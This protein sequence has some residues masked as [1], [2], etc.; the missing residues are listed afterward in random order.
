MNFVYRNA[1]IEF[2]LDKGW[3]CSGYAD[4]STVPEGDGVS[5]WWY[6][7]P[8]S[9]DRAAV[10]DEVRAFPDML[11]LVLDRTKQTREVVARRG[12]STATTLLKTQWRN[13]T[14]DT[15]RLPGIFQT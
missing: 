6:V 3:V 14:Q 8:F 1:T 4:V 9:Y 13:A 12:L 7:L 5:L 2:F 15:V 10:A 11:R